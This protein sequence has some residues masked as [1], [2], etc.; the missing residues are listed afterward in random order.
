MGSALMVDL[1]LDV[2]LGSCLF[3]FVTYIMIA[4]SALL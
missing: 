1:A 2:L 3:A 4:A